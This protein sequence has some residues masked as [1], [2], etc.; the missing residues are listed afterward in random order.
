MNIWPG[1]NSVFCWWMFDNFFSQEKAPCFVL[2]TDMCSVNT[3]VDFT[4]QS[5]NKLG[6][7]KRWFA[8]SSPAQHW[9]NST[10]DSFMGYLVIV[11][12]IWR[13]FCFML[14]QKD[15][16]T[17]SFLDLHWVLRY[18]IW[19]DS[20]TVKPGFKRPSYGA[21]IGLYI[22]VWALNSACSVVWSWLCFKNLDF[23]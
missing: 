2:F 19:N 13:A 5:D 11:S 12:S 18:F 22:V 4:Y 3:M 15:V 6:V 7:R 20:S 23:Q 9:H 17:N 21:N 8:S 14:V 16:G 1:C 10:A